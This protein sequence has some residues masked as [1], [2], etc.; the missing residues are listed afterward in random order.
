MKEIDA[1]VKDSTAGSVKLKQAEEEIRNIIAE[2]ASELY[3]KKKRARKRPHNLNSTRVRKMLVECG[4]GKS[5]SN[6]PDGSRVQRASVHFSFLLWRIS[7]ALRLK[8]E[9]TFL[10]RDNK[11]RS[12]SWRWDTKVMD[13]ERGVLGLETRANIIG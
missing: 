1:I 3:L 4:V 9:D 10:S 2:L 11:L 12:L 6:L 13:T 5:D 7:S 8:T